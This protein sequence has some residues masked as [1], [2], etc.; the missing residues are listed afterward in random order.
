MQ[1][2][3]AHQ[4]V[5]ADTEALLLRR[6]QR[7]SDCLG[8]LGWRLGGCLA[9]T[10]RGREMKGSSGREPKSDVGHGDATTPPPTISAEY[11]RGWTAWRV[12]MSMGTPNVVF[13]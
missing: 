10:L 2:T 11:G 1:A 13:Q 4:N 5:S 7:V 12:P 9:S 6:V 8:R 3:R